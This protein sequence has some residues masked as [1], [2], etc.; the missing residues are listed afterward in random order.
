MSSAR[1]EPFSS[2]GFAARWEPWEADG[3]G[4]ELTIA[5]DNEAWTVSGI[6]GH[7]QVQYVLRV[8]PTWHVRQMLLFRDMEDPD[9]WLGT[10]GSGHWGEVNGAHRHDLAGCTDVFLSCTPFGPTVPLRRLGLGVGETAEIAA[11]EV[12]VETLAATPTHYRMTRLGERR[13]R[14][15]AGDA[16]P[17]ELDVDEHGLP[18]DAPGRFRR[19]A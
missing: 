1:Y 3:T 6:V 8:S 19:V 2:D 17:V 15:I 5:W 11:I 9:L 4:E 12:D 7:E 13:W 16:E 14:M 18:L 10:D